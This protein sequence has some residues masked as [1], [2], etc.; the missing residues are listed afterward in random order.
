MTAPDQC[1][2]MSKKL[3][4]IRRRPHMTQSGRC[5][6]L[7]FPSCALHDQALRF[8]TALL[9]RCHLPLQVAE[10]ARLRAGAVSCEE[11]RRGIRLVPCAPAPALRGRSDGE[12]A[13]RFRGTAF[14]SLALVAES[15]A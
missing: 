5:A 3:L 2:I 8:A 15:G 1:C 10:W 11:T 12:H 9:V 6:R 14:R 13:G 4:S 7:P